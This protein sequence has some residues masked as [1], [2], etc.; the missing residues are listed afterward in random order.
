MSIAS[1]GLSHDERR[2]LRVAAVVIKTGLSRTTIWRMVRAGQFPPP[3]ALSERA[4]GWL[5][6][7]IDRFI[8]ARAA[9]R[10][11]RL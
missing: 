9:K 5:S 11:V 8:E 10:Q 4:T 7:E 3:I 1:T 2:I 6:D